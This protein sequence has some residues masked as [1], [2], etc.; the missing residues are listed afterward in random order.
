MLKETYS[1]ILRFLELLDTLWS[2]VHLQ[3]ALQYV[4]T[5]ELILTM[6]LFLTEH[7]VEIVTND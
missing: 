4:A 3:E 7:P 1:F 5:P 2:T 6:N